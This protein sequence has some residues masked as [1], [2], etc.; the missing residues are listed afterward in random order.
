MALI[1]IT[2][3]SLMLISGAAFYGSSLLKE[4]IDSANRRNVPVVK[5]IYEVKVKQQELAILFFRYALADSDVE[6][7]LIADRRIQGRSISA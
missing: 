4:S 6:R 3:A 5:G 7:K 2:L 1:A